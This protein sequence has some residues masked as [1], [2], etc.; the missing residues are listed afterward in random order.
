MEKRRSN[1]TKH[2]LTCELLVGRE[3]YPAVVRDLAPTGLFVQTRA[4]PDAN[5]V[6][7]VR[8][9]PMADL[10]GFCIE[11]GVARHRNVHPRLQS[12]IHAG[13]G[14][15]ILGRPAAY[16]ALARR[17]G[18]PRAPGGPIAGSTPPETILPASAGRA[19]AGIAPAPSPRSPAPRSGIAS[20]RAGLEP[21]LRRYRVRLRSHGCTPPRTLEVQASSLP[22]ARALAMAQAGPGWKITDVQTI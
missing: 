6:V 19:M 20:L 7:E 11:A 16:L 21:E 13:V 10:P 3:T 18:P 15:E 8:F 1:R 12:E 17:V 5:S 22:T 2:R 9:P 4:R 14:L